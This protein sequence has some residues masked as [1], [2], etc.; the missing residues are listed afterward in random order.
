M[1]RWSR[2]AVR[3]PSGWSRKRCHRTLLG[4]R[5]RRG[6]RQCRAVG[7]VRDGSTR[8]SSQQRL[9]RHPGNGP[10][11]L[12]TVHRQPGGAS[13]AG[14]AIAACARGSA[15]SLVTWAPAGRSTAPVLPTVRVIP[16]SAPGATVAPVAGSEASAIPSRSA[17]QPCQC[18]WCHCP[19]CP[20]ASPG[21]TPVNVTVA[22]SVI[23]ATIAPKARAL[24]DAT[25]R[26]IPILTMC[27]P[28]HSFVRTRATTGDT[29]TPRKRR[30]TIGRVRVQLVVT[31]L[32]LVWD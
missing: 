1:P 7:V 18:S 30:R 21:L 15:R 14:S 28:C 32:S 29:R 11:E 20:L 9:S 16:T 12:R 3:P 4:I 10:G 23:D 17:P 2:Q 8:S 24:P 27:H 31:R 22:T 13:F 25:R 5:G 6:D 19:R 26:C